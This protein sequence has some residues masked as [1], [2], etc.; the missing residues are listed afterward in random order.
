MNLAE[1]CESKKTDIMAE[2]QRQG[3][4]WRNGTFR[5]SDGSRG[6]FTGA[7]TYRDGKGV[8][9]SHFVFISESASLNSS[10]PNPSI[11]ANTL[12]PT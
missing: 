3:G 2:V 8:L 12:P 5:F 4:V 10:L 11:P 1:V 9:R 6:S 7:A